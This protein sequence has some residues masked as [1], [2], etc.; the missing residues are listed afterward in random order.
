MGASKEMFLRMREDDFNKLTQDVRNS[1]T[2]VE[3]VE[4]NEWMTHRSDPIYLSMYNEKKK[5]ND[6]IKKY[7]FDKRHK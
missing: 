4:A 6:K 7:L 1:F 3:V 5:I 2:Y